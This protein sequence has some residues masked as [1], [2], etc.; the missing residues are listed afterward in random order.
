MEEIRFLTVVAKADATIQYRIIREKFKIRIHRPDL[1]NAISKFRRESTPG[2]A[3]AGILLKRLHEKKIEDPRW[4]V[5]M[6]LD[7]ITSSLTHLFWMSSEQQIL[8]W[9]ILLQNYPQAKDYLIR[10]LGCNFQSWARAFTSKYFTASAQTTSR[11]E[12]ENSVLKRLFGN[13]NLSLCELFDALEE[14][15]QEE[16]DYCEFINWHQTIPQIRPQ[17]VSTSIFGPVA[18]QLNE[19]VMPNIMKKQEEQMEL[20]LYY[21][22]VEI[23]LEIL[24]SKEMILD[25]SNQCIDNLFDCP[26]VQ[27]SLF[28]E[29]TL[30]ILEVWEVVYLTSQKTSHFVC[31]LNNGTFLCTCMINKTHGYPCR[32]FYRVMTLTSTARFHIGLV[33]QRWYKDILQ[34]TD[35][36]N[37]E[38][39]AISSMKMSALKTHSLPTQFLNSNGSA[40][41]VG[42]SAINTEITKSISKKRKFGELWGLGRKVMVDVIENN[43]EDTYREL[44]EVF[45]SIQKKLQPRIVV[46]NSNGGVSN[47]NNNGESDNIMN[48][49]NP[50]ERRPKGRPKSNK[51]MKNTLELSNIKTQYT[52]KLCKQKGHNSKTCKEKLDNANKE[53]EVFER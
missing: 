44:C 5:S 51:R 27:I 1:Y 53:N 25:E 15:Y 8:W 33:N 2:E 13:S 11:N 22:A 14:R 42:A 10:S 29:D 35:I 52:C 19:F 50:V 9:E 45:L 16:V 32:H 34:G 26:Q 37:K 46:D 3:D 24:H 38:F 48:I 43:N 41:Q 12:G 30:L 7:P 23:E 21:H 31:L 20:S 47:S 6:K 49:R 36:S 40:I 17:N 18:Q 28:L 4:V 39:V